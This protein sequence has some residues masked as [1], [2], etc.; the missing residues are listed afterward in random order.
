MFQPVGYFQPAS[1]IRETHVLFVTR[2]RDVAVTRTNVAKC[3]IKFMVLYN[4]VW[5]S[6][7]ASMLCSHALQIVL[8]C[9][10]RYYTLVQKREWCSH[11]GMLPSLLRAKPSSNVIL[12]NTAGCL[13]SG[14]TTTIRSQPK[15]VKNHPNTNSSNVAHATISQ[16]QALPCWW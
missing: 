15:R 6:P 7:R 4:D 9:R 16:P 2:T 8:Q 3:K 1:H 5:L 10:P 12:E 14:A 13:P 11:H